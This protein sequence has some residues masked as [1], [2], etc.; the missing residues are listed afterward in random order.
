[1]LAFCFLYSF[2]LA[3]NLPSLLAGIQA[4]LKWLS[5]WKST[6]S[7]HKLILLSEGWVV[8]QPQIPLMGSS[9]ACNKE[10][11]LQYGPPYV[12]QIAHCL[13]LLQLP[14]AFP[15]LSSLPFSHWGLQSRFFFLQLLVL[16]HRGG[17]FWKFQVVLVD[18]MLCPISWKHVSE[19][20]S[21]SKFNDT[22]VWHSLLH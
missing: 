13:Y 20:G 16:F 14:E 8:V 15:G 18:G 5:S 9:W 22:T 10:N 11:F 1:M 19:A 7:L 12:K 2:M 4:S 21:L 6:S 17:S 3:S